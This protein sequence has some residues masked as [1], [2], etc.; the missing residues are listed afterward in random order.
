MVGYEDI[1]SKII[2][3]PGVKRSQATGS[4]RIHTCN[5]CGKESVWDIGWRWKYVFHKGSKKYSDPGWE[6]TFKTCSKECR[7]GK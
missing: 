1:M 2:Q 6:E 7:N 5:V 3:F 4:G